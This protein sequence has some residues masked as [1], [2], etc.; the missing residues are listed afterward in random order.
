MKNFTTLIKFAFLFLTANT[1]FGQN[2]SGGTGTVGDP[3]QIATLADLEYLSDNSTDWDKFFIQTANIDATVTNT[4]NVGDHDNDGGA[5]PDEAM[6]FIPIGDYFSNRFTGSYNGN[7]FAISNLYIN[8]PGNLYIGLFGSVSMVNREIINVNLSNVNI[9][10]GDNTG[11][12][13]GGVDFFYGPGLIQNCHVSGSVTGKSKTGGLIGEFT[14]HS[15]DKITLKK[16]SSNCVVSGT[17]TVGG[18]CGALERGIVVECT[19]NGS[20][21]SISD[22]AGFS[23]TIDLNATVS[24]CKSNANV[25]ASLIAAGFTYRVFG[26]S[27]IV[28]FCSSHGDVT[29]TGASASGFTSNAYNQ[30]TIRDCY[31]ISNVVGSTSAAAFVS[32]T[33]N[34]SL[35]V[36]CYSG[37]TLTTAGDKAGFCYD[38]LDGYGST[39]TNCYWDTDVSGTATSD[40]GAGLTTAQMQTRSNFTS[41]D[42]LGET[43]NGTDDHWYMD[44]C[45]S[46]SYPKLRYFQTFFKGTGTSGDPY[47]IENK[48]DLKELSENQCFASRYFKQT[49]DVSFVSADFQSGGDFYNAGKGFRSILLTGTYDGDNHFIDGIYHNETDPFNANCGMF[50]RIDGTVTD[51]ALTNVQVAGGGGHF[52]GAFAGIIDGTVSNCSVTGSLNSNNFNGGFAASIGGTASVSNCYA[53]VN[54]T[55]GSRTGGFVGDISGATGDITNCYSSGVVSGSSLVGGFIGNNAGGTINIS[56]CFWNTETSGQSSSAGGTGLTSSQMK[57]QSTLTSAT[58]DFSTIWKMG[59]C[60]NNGFPVFAWQTI[61]NYPTVSSPVADNTCGDG[62]VTLEA[63]PSSSATIKWY[64]AASGGSLIVDDA[65]FDLS[66]N[67]LT[68]VNLTATTSYY[69]EADLSGCNSVSRVEVVATHTALPTVSSLSPASRCGSG[70]ITI[71]ATSSAGNI[72]WY[73]AS[74]GGN[75]ITDDANYDLSGNNLT[76]V[77]LTGTTSFYAQ[78]ENG[79][80]VNPT[81]S[82]VIATIQTCYSGGIGTIGD[83]Y[84]ISNKAD[85]KRLSETS[86]DWSSHFIQTAS[87]SFTN[88]DFENGG[89]FY[90]AGNGFIPIGNTT[91][92]FS[93]RYNGQNYTIENLFINRPSANNIGFFGYGNSGLNINNIKLINIDIE[94]NDHVGGLIGQQANNGDVTNCHVTGNIKGNNNYCGG[95]IGQTNG[96]N[97]SN[98]SANATIYAFNRAGGFIG[99]PRFGNISQCFSDGTVTIDEN[100]NAFYNGGFFGANNS[101]NFTNCYT[102]VDI[103]ANDYSCDIAG[104]GGSISNGT[105]TNCYASN[106]L[107]GNNLRRGFC[108]DNFGATFTSCYWN[109]SLTS[110]NGA[111][112]TGVSGKTSSEL[113]TQGTFSGYNFGS[114]WKMDLGCPNNGYPIFQW[115]TSQA[116]PTI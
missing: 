74:S 13:I 71:S 62:S 29:S 82:E 22:G 54:V 4:W 34:L 61:T 104:F 24:F 42:F 26:T 18:F 68:K 80:C 96:T 53:T 9:T 59:Q 99:N 67:N 25:V 83:P 3:Y 23:G 116:R 106:T 114:I 56:N 101:G 32:N 41:W 30:S 38:N 86:A 72:K 95:L 88:A 58:W 81:R 15:T 17:S 107:T 92:G 47:L 21:S 50:E 33:F 111:A 110:S 60:T 94:G 79:T 112:I 109:T 103:I 28:E 84:Q 2:Y 87:I 78:A 40:G 46:G 6:G 70:S 75:L 20:V 100:A 8:R 113:Q 93:G 44:D 48:Q 63:T 36:R 57:T 35:F 89:G 19:S 27:T 66:G 14:S 11:A 69:A 73:D 77:N 51:L 64:D 45:A 10:G 16:S 91:T 102:T 49:A 90:N 37:S 31:T 108:V 5:T 52:N 12:L 7:N 98:S 115:Q 1:L 85:L 55:G 97:V 76:I 105:F 65:N 39:I 43:T